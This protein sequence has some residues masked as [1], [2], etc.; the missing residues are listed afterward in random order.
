[1]CYGSFLLL[2]N[3]TS[4]IEKALLK[5]ITPA[6]VIDSKLVGGGRN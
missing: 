2:M 1:M 3:L 6:Q 5:T 4:L